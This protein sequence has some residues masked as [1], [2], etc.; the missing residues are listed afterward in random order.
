MRH[1][2]QLWCRRITKHDDGIECAFLTLAASTVAYGP[3]KRTRLM[4]ASKVGDLDRIRVLLAAGAHIDAEATNGGTA[5]GYAAAYGHTAAFHL[6]IAK[7]ASVH[8]ILLDVAYDELS[9]LWSLKPQPEEIVVPARRTLPMELVAALCRV[10]RALPL[11]ALVV[12]S[13]TTWP[14]W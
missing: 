6:L 2:P 13:S 7:G 8:N 14:R 1:A 11:Y 9:A 10:P 12:A 4:H 5:L 3:G